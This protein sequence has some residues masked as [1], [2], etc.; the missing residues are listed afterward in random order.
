MGVPRTQP[1]VADIKKSLM[2]TPE[3]I[4]AKVMQFRIVLFE[5]PSLWISV[6]ISWMVLRG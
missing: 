4:S 1:T 2:A 6:T 5:L 3:L